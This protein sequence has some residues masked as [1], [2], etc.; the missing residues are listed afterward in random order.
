MRLPAFRAALI[1]AVAFVPRLDRVCLAADANPVVFPPL[2][3]FKEVCTDGSW[4]LDD[5]LQLAEQRHFAPR[6]ASRNF[7]TECLMKHVTGGSQA[8][9]VG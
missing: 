5:L 9:R 2:Q 8:W 7:V 1:I 4:S 6:V 3:I